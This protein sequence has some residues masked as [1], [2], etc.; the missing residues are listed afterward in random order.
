MDI[1]YAADYAVSNIYVL[2]NT[3]VLGDT[4]SFANPVAFAGGGRITQIEIGDFD[5]DGLVDILTCGQQNNISVFKNNSTVTSVL[6]QPRINLAT[7]K[8]VKYACIA[9]FDGDGK[10]DIAASTENYFNNTKSVTV[11]KNA[12]SLN[13][14]SFNAI[15][16]IKLNTFST[17]NIIAAD[18]DGDGMQDILIGRSNNPVILRNKIGKPTQS[19]LCATANNFTVHSNITGAN[20]QWQT[21]VDNFNYVNLNND[22]TYNGT[23]TSVLTLLN[24]STLSYGTFFRCKV[25]NIY[26]TVS[27]LIF[28]N[29][30]V[31]TVDSAWENPA[32]WS[33]GKLPNATT[34]VVINSGTV[35]LSSNASCRSIKVLPGASF[36]IVPGF[37]LSV[38]H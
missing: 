9:D 6:F 21:S 36:T 22:T 29:L 37:T 8:A 2:L 20:Y 18:I 3:T 19:I 30:W 16:E 12:S 25:G 23:N 32:N 38:T 13:T 34:D 5:N 10:V 14:I 4:I 11:F 27:K 17:Q 33:C 1:L 24:P 35:I 28:Q 15:K 31:G 26:S 7:T